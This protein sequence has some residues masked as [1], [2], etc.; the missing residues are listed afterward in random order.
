M[1]RFKI[2]LEYINFNLWRK[3]LQM[4]FFKN[5]HKYIFHHIPK[6]AGTSFKKILNK[7]F[8]VKEDY[9]DLNKSDDISKKKKY[10]LSKFRSNHCLAGH[11]ASNGIYLYQRYPEIFSSQKYRIISFIRE[12]LDLIISLYYYEKMVGRGSKLQLK[13]Y[14]FIR[15]NYLANRFPCN[16]DNYM[17]VLDKYF[18]I[19]I[20]ERMEESVTLLSKKLGKDNIKMDSLNSSKK[21]LQKN[22]ITK[23]VKQKFQEINKLDYLIYQ[24]CNDKLDR[25]I[26]NEG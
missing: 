16:Q 11:F 5:N 10:N 4:I 25:L 17:D 18:F 26:L 3:I 7:W 22:D 14:I 23:E 8:I 12:P 21:D 6:T 1:V 19:G 20:T 15:Q 2:F 9:R 24:Y 13:D